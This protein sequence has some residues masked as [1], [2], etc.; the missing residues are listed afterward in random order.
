[1]AL[2]RRPPSFAHSKFVAPAPS[3][4]W[5]VRPALYARLDDEQRG[6]LGLVIGSPGAGKTSLLAQ[7]VHAQIGATAWLSADHADLDPGRFWYGFLTALR[8]SRPGFAEDCLDLLALDEHVDQDVLECLLDATERLDSPLTLV[9]DD[10]HLVGRAAHDH[11]RFLVSRGLGRLRVIVGSRSEPAIGLERLRL[12]D[13]LCELREADLRFEPDQAA[14]LFGRLHAGL[15]P[16]ELDVVVRRTEGW[17]AGVQLAAIALRDVEDPQR[18]VERLGGSHQIVS[19]YLSAEVYEAQPPDVRQF[20][21]DTCIVEE[22]TP[23]LAGAL[24]PTSGVSLL[25]I[26]AAG[27]FLSRLDPGGTTF[28]YHQLFAE[29][30]RFQLR[31]TD[32]QH[33]FTLHERAARWHR[34]RHDPVGAFRH[35]WRAGQRTEAMRSIHGTVLDIYYGGNLPTLA[36]S[37][38]ALTDDDLLAGPGPAV[39]FCSTLVLAGYVDEAE[40]LAERIESIAGS[41]LGPEDRL[42]LLVVRMITSLLRGDTRATLR[43]GGAVLDRDGADGDEWFGIGVSLLARAH[44]WEG[45]V[46]AGEALLAGRP[47][48]GASAVERIETRGALAHVR[49]LQGRLTDCVALATA[50]LGD[51]RDEDVAGTS[52]G[53]LPR[54]VLGCALLEQGNIDA[55]EQALRAISEVDSPL[56][57]AVGVLAKVSLSRIWRA[58]GSFDA[59][60]VVLEDAGQQFHGQPPPRGVVEY[61]DLQRAR[62][63]VDLDD[64]ADAAIDALRDG[65]DRTLLGA[66]LALRRGDVGGCRRLLD[67]LGDVAPTHRRRLDVALAWLAWTVASGADPHER[68]AGVFELAAAEHF[69]FPI[70][71]AGQDVL[72]AVQRAARQR[73]QSPFVDALL[74]ARPAAVAPGTPRGANAVDALSE[75]ERTV[76]R[77]LATSLSYTEIAE[78]LFVSPNTVK[79]HVRHI[80]TKLHVGSRREAVKRARDLRYL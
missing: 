46:A 48:P 45:D 47:R 70:A 12:D 44:I 26:E 4:T 61:I 10:F 38:R 50:A 65:T 56:R 66:R 60:L 49:L 1:V 74:R 30:L 68:A 11:L 2:L 76:L 15:T 72:A 36:E 13:K 21:L 19:R 25:D 55:A 77:Y 54:G 23:G 14:E 67:A 78:A 24:S 53:L 52:V 63:R 31:A 22:L 7:W 18:V 41:R 59:A 8:L 69:V 16:G 29:M 37:E 6:R 62:V 33:E 27:L 42:Q 39:S 79:T 58:E 57:I 9:I 17:A 35:Q 20:L 3:A 28:R 51:I 32:P 43:L 75:R 71:E 34:E 40:R 80:V 64:G 73:P 5:V